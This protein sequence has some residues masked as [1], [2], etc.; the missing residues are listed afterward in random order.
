MGWL[1]NFFV[2]P[3]KIWEEAAEKLGGEFVQGKVLM[4]SEIHFSHRDISIR[5][6]V[7]YIRV[8]TTALRTRS[9]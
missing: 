7:N 3:D 9:R 8:R 6:I 1:R 2:F 5:L 4:N